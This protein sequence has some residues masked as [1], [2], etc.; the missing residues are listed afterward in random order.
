MYELMM[1]AREFSSDEPDEDMVTLKLRTTPARNRLERKHD[2]NTIYKPRAIRG[3]I[4]AKIKHR[5]IIT[6][7][8]RDRNKLR[9]A[10]ATGRRG[11]EWARAPGGEKPPD[12]VSCP[13]SSRDFS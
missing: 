8:N 3:V 2:E 1:S 7:G 5:N 13:F 10:L 9:G 4:S 12:F 6:G 11:L